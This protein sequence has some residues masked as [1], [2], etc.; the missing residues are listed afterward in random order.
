MATKAIVSPPTKLVCYGEENNDFHTR[1]LRTSLC[2]EE[3]RAYWEHSR[4]DIPKNKVAVVAFEERWFGSK[5]MA[6]VRSLLVELNY[7]FESYPVALLLLR[8]WCPSDPVTR[9]NICHW[10]MQLTDPLYRNFT[11]F[12]L[13]QR[14]QQ[15]NANLDRSIVARWLTGQ[16]KNDW[17]SATTL[18]MA[19]GLIGAC[20]A[21]GLCTGNTGMRQLQ[22]PKVSDDALTYWLYFLRHV[23]FTGS[24]L[25]NPYLTSVGLSESF[26]E[27]RL[28]RLSS[29]SF[30]RMGELYDFGWDY[31]D[32]KT[33]AI[34]VLGIKW[35]DK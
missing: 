11:G 33:W 12:F 24:L 29:I 19:T 32:L 14:R 25:D 26:L 1:L 4:D 6:R 35:E 30:N 9:Q 8:Y 31:P 21:A 22:Y 34:Q 10:H 3:S 23:K 2:L 28:R 15:P 7:R 17:S 18:R 5:S 20:A 16:I 27:Q 13:E